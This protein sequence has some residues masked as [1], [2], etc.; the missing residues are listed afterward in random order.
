MNIDKM[1]NKIINPSPSIKS[2][3]L[4][5]AKVEKMSELARSSIFFPFTQ[6]TVKSPT[7]KVIKGRMPSMER[8]MKNFG[9]KGFDIKKDKQSKNMAWTKGFKTDPNFISGGWE[10]NDPYYEKRRVLMDPDVFL[11]RQYQQSGTNGPFNE[12]A[13]PTSQERVDNIVK[14][15]KS[16]KDEVP[17]PIEEYDYY[18]Q[19]KDFQEGRHRGLAAKQLGIKIPVLMGRKRFA[20]WDRAAEDKPFEHREVFFYTKPE[21]GENKWENEQDR[22]PIDSDEQSQ[23]L[24]WFK[25]Q[26]KYIPLDSREYQTKAKVASEEYL[27]PYGEVMTIPGKTVGRGVTIAGVVVPGAIPLPAAVV[28]GKYISDKVENVK[29][30]KTDAQDRRYKIPRLQFNTRSKNDIWEDDVSPVIDNTSKNMKIAGKTVVVQSKLPVSKKLIHNV[31]SKIPDDTSIPIVFQTKKQYLKEYIKNQEKKKNIDYPKKQEQQ[32][33]K[34]ELK[35]YKPII[36][37]YT[38]KKNPYIDNRVVFFTDNKVT[39]KQFK[40]S[41]WHEYGHE[42]YEKKGYKGSRIEEERFAR[43]YVLSKDK[44]SKDKQRQ[45]QEEDEDI[46]FRGPRRK[47]KEGE[48]WVKFNTP[49]GKTI[50]YLKKKMPSMQEVKDIITTPWLSDDEKR[51]QLTK[52][53][54][55]PSQERQARMYLRVGKRRY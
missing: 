17:I 49:E 13:Q 32:Y 12:W 41:A 30:V 9:L 28:A 54:A 10:K 36:A 19:R 16:K 6:P 4:V 1:I 18:G 31:Y 43:N 24:S 7:G 33:I 23:N 44:Q 46:T 26:D 34:N 5:G 2:P 52:I 37:R 29:L 14:G 21:V 20:P 55:T 40:H 48:Q 42:L 25:K 45:N 47:A 38:T 3:N 15:I 11:Q 27:Q 22:F 8:V 35:E 39:P 50:I 53:N 51:L